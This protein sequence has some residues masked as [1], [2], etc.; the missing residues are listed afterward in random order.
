MAAG[1]AKSEQARLRRLVAGL[2]TNAAKI[3]TLAQAGVARADIARFLGVRYQQ[4]RNTLVRARP[5]LSEEK[6]PY[7]EQVE[8]AWLTIGKD[9]RVV[10]PVAFRRLLGA[11]HGGPVQI[12]IQ[13]GEVCLVGRDE[14]V[15]RVQARIKRLIPPGISLA[16]E[17]IAERR[18]EAAHEDQEEREFRER[19]RT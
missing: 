19:R 3:R 16:D 18:A 4:V 15:R 10:I 2:A 11:E 17:L 6:A 5:G 14:V 12:R 9:G 7:G 8:R 1:I 13:D